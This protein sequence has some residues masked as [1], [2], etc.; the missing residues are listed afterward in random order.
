VSDLKLFVPEQ[1]KT[2]GRRSDKISAQIKECLANELTKGNFP[3]LPGHETESILPTAIT[4]TYVNLSPDLRNAMI[5]FMPLGGIKRDECFKFLKLQ[6]Y[7]FKNVMAK[8][9]RL[10][11]MP[12]IAFKLDESFDYSE[13]IESLI[14]EI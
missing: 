4:I 7:H 6:S 14:N 12:S 5:Y 11:F 13:K 3:I 9:L 1:I 10:K 2:T 8:K